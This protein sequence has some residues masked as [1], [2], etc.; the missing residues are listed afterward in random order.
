MRLSVLL[1]VSLNLET[2][3][4]NHST[5]RQKRPDR[6]HWIKCANAELA[7]GSTTA[8]ELS[9]AGKKTVIVAGASEGLPAG[10][11]RTFMDRWHGEQ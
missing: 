1:A 8:K 7:V 4:G 10:D 2:A 11:A 9:M 5:Q 3:L 6:S